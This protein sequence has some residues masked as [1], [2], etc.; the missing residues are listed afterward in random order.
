MKT[1]KNKTGNNKNKLLD[2]IKTDNL[3]EI[4]RALKDNTVDINTADRQG[5]T[6]F[7]LAV[8][9]K[10]GT[11]LALLLKRTLDVISDANNKL[12]EA[13]KTKN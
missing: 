1:K 3:L 5:D 11:I 2:A 13:T 12:L 9:K 6:A 4:T 8:Q 7:S 10:D